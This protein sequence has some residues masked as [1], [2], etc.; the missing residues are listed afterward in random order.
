MY[1]ENKEPEATQTTAPALGMSLC[2][3]LAD[4]AH[5]PNNEEQKIKNAKRG[6]VNYDKYEKAVLFLKG[7][8]QT[9]VIL[10]RNTAFTTDEEEI[11]WLSKILKT[12]LL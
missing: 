9:S 6:G 2:C 11:R 3:T 4:C 7:Y 10:N 1:T 5:E 8:F 12:K